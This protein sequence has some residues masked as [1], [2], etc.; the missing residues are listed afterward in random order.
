M[1]GKFADAYM[2]NLASII[3]MHYTNDTWNLAAVIL[4]KML[5]GMNSMK[6]YPEIVGLHRLFT[7]ARSWRQHLKNEKVSYR[8]M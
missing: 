3:L 7:M 6:A 8:N 2:H 5:R 1:I 4:I